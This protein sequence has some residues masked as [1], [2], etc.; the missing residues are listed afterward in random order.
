[1]ISKNELKFF[2]SL[3]HKKYRLKENKF[4]VEGE[5]IV[6]E[7]LKSNF[8]CDV[9]VTT[10]SFADQNEQLIS[11]LVSNKIRI[12]IASALD[13]KRISDTETTQGIIGVF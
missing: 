1:M 5:K 8:G 9:I 7:G 10:P 2:S 13:F 3:L 12:E 11:S 6:L 4:L